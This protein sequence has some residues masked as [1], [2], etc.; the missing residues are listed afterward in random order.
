MQGKTQL[1]AGELQGFWSVGSLKGPCLAH[2]H[3]LV[4]E[5]ANDTVFRSWVSGDLC[6]PSITSWVSHHIT[7]QPHVQHW[8][9][10]YPSTLEALIH[11]SPHKIEIQGSR[12]EMSK[13]HLQRMRMKMRMRGIDPSAAGMH[14]PQ[15]PL[16]S[17]QRWEVQSCSKWPI[18]GQ[19]SSLIT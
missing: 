3:S 8:C 13:S 16:P 1:V 6:N 19:V 7:S 10:L 4:Q 11:L 2:Y 15:H 12:M 9:C 17:K 14:E 5:S 18:A